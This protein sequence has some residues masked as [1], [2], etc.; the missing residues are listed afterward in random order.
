MTARDA[1][2]H[3]EIIRAMRDVATAIG[4]SEVRFNLRPLL[5]NHH[6]YG[7]YRV[8]RAVS[9]TFR[10][11]E[12]ENLYILPPTSYVDLED[13]ANPTLKSLVLSRYAMDDI[14]HAL[15]ASAL[16]DISGVAG[17]PRPELIAGAR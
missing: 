5:T 3:G 6:A 7:A 10:F 16:G 17:M 2:F 13:D 1:A 4:L 8:G 12:V 9:R 14:V 15:T 11:H